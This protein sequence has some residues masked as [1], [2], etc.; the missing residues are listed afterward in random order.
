MSRIVADLAKVQWARYYYVNQH[1]DVTDY[2]KRYSVHGCTYKPDI[3]ALGVG[4]TMDELA[5][6]KGIKDVWT[7]HVDLT[8]SSNH[9]L[10]FKGKRAKSIWKEWNRRQFNKKK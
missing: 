3:I 7:P 1:G 5:V 10:T 2:F 6:L 4:I 9:R 8:F